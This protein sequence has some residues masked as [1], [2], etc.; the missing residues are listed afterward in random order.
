MK[1]PTAVIHPDEPCHGLF[2]GPRKGRWIQ[3]I[4]VIRGDAIASWTHDYGSA[5]N[6]TRIQPFMMPSYGEN[7]V[8]QLQA[9]AEKNRHDTYW[10]NRVGE[11]KAE[12]TLIA[13]VLRQDEEMKL[14]IKNRSVIGPYRTVQRNLH[15]QQKVREAI[16]EKRTKSGKRIY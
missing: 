6:F 16:K 10:A 2:E 11:M 14:Q 8:A 4:F 9:H 13:D 5:S 1:I 15:S 7:T 12:S 3:Q